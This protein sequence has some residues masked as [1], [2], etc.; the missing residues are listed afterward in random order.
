MYLLLI[1][2]AALARDF[3]Q[4]LF[5]RRIPITI[6]QSVYNGTVHLKNPQVLGP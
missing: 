4:K 6:Q 1:G 2:F 3:V 5:F